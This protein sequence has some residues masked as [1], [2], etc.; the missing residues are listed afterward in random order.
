MFSLSKKVVLIMGGNGLIGSAI[1]KGAK[2]AGAKVIVIDPSKP[3]VE[4]DQFFQQDLINKEQETSQLFENIRKTHGKI[5]GFVNCSYPRTADWG[6]GLF[7]VSFES[8]RQ[9]IDLH[10]NSYFMFSRSISEI[11]CSQGFGSIINFS[12][13]YG[14]VGPNFSI[15]EGTTISNPP[16][17]AAIK[18]GISNL[19]RY[20]AAST[21]PQGVRVNAIC[22]GGVENGQ[23]EKFVENYNKITPLRRMATPGDNVGPTIF[24]LS[25]ASQYITGVN[26]PVDGGWTSI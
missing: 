10:L 3:Q 25:D 19:T 20:L 12:S 26:L 17:Y 2:E 24:L 4:V 13:I 23:P 7:D 14:L 15:Y 22:P 11:M 6:K 18:G 9:N 8:W 21:G 1:S 16:A 5:D